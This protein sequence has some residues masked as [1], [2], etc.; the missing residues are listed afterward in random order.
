MH[1]KILMF[2]IYQSFEK[3]L[4]A[5]KVSTNHIKSQLKINKYMVKVFEQG[6]LLLNYLFFG[7]NKYTSNTMAVIFI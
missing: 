2:Q 1:R 6:T 5:Q 3:R 7:N 4:F